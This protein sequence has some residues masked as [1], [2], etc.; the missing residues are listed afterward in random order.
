MAGHQQDSVYPLFIVQQVKEAV[1]Q[2][3]FR[4]HLDC[5][6]DYC[7]HF[8]AQSACTCVKE[9][10][11]KVTAK[12]QAAGTSIFTSMYVL[13]AYTALGHV[14]CKHTLYSFKVSF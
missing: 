7:L 8:R 14:Q 12:Q 3:C 9:S 2:G 11:L 13:H 1:Q 6:W 4:A 5:L 10:A